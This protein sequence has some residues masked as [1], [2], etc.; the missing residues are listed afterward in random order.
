MQLQYDFSDKNVLITGAAGGIGKAV[1]TLFRQSGANIYL[2]D[3]DAHELDRVVSLFPNGSGQIAFSKF[4][5]EN[6]DSTTA[7]ITRVVE[8]F[9]GDI[10]ILIPAAG[11]YPEQSVAEMSAED[12]QQV[13]SVNLN[14]V[15]NTI[16]A[17]IPYLS[18]SAAIVNFASVAGHRGS[19]FHAH[20]ASSKAGILA[21]T[22][23]LALELG[24]SVRVN[25][26]SPGTILTKMVQNLVESRGSE[27]V[28][29]TPLQRN[30]RPE[31]VAQVVAFLAS[32]AA[33]FV[34]GE[35]VHV[36]GG[37]FMAS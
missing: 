11:I 28:A 12:W 13:I 35:T 9:A 6:V 2:A 34:N 30:G 32:D 4:D 7:L 10:D 21:L 15:F 16:H 37:L 14:G 22:R 29:E 26:V 31:E 5:C 17:A 18:Q 3:V 8:Q 36:N 25:A 33:S 23:S 1:A 27:L 24:P 20:Y 19:K